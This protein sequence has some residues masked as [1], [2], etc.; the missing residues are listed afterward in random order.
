MRLYYNTYES[1]CAP[2][3]KRKKN[4]E[5]DYAPLSKKKNTYESDYT[6]IKEE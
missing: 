6:L 5:I 3:L 2:L 4:Y 1:D